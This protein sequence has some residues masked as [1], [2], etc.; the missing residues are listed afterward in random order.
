MALESPVL[1]DGDAGFIGFASRVNPVTLPAGMLQDSVNM[2]LDRGVA[3]TRRGSKRLTDTIG[4][5]GSPLT[6]NFSLASDRAITSITFSSTTATV[7][8]T[9][10]HG[11]LDGQ[12]VNIRGAEAPDDVFYNGD[13]II[14]GA[15]ATTFTYTMTGTPANN[16]SGTLV[17]NNGPIVRSTYEGGLYAAGIFASQNYQNANEYIVLVGNDQAYLYRQGVSIDTVGYPTEGVAE[18]VEGTDRVSV[19]QAFDRLY[20]LREA[21]QTANTEWAARLLGVSVGTCA[22]SNASPAVVTRTAHGL[23][24][25]MAVTFSTTGTLPTGLTAGTIYYI[26]NK[27]DNTF[28]VSATSGGSAINTS[29]AGSGTHSVRPVSAVV[30]GTTATIFAKA[31]PYVYGHRVRFENGGPAAFDGH[32]FDV[33]ASPA[34]TT[35]TFAVTVPSGTANDT[36]SSAV[37]TTRRVKPPIYWEG[38]TGGFVRAAGGVPPAGPSFTGM[39]SVGWA[40]Y[41]N[42]RLWLARNRDTVAISDVLDADTYDPFW[43]SFRVGAGGGDRIVAIHP[44]VEGQALVFCR[45]SIWL[46]TLNQFASTDG[47]DFSV[48]TP[49][50]NITL[51]TNEVGCSARET[52]ATVGQYVFFLSDA[53]I[54]RLDSRLDLKL[55][56][57]SKPLSEPIADKFSAVVQSRVEDSA[58]AVWHDNRYIIALPTS[59]DPLDGNQLVMAFNS[60]NEQWE[61]RDEFPSSAAVNEMLVSTYDNQRRIFSIPRSGNIYVLDEEN[62]AIDDEASG[63]LAGSN[64]VIGRIKTRRYDFRDM[65]SKRFLRTIADVVIPPGASIATKISVINPDKTGEIGLLQNDSNETEDYNMKSPI[66]Y[67]AH[68]A[69]LIFETFNGRPEIRSAS[70]EASPKSLP[71]TE[72]RS[73]A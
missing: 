38:G 62:D 51:L 12:Q 59:D 66:R 15:T 20:I 65:H 37:R 73:A 41:H 16:A 46:A 29:S 28:N 14:G 68:S 58:V 8:T 67:K 13:F 69:E 34:P 53:G 5:A 24:N 56:G 10:A 7:T 43:S 21:Q 4:V 9:A 22:I 55:R 63:S 18:T 57:D 45:K 11:Y 35:H 19:A 27:A 44:W 64:P 30:S 31:H 32:E 54:Y 23:E 36:A 2:R 39:P 17:A 48:D 25:G 26:I 40:S 49:V 71:P 47:S 70:I 60:L 1:R 61:Y 6:L 52:I 33:L 50:T 3:T 42:N 72:T